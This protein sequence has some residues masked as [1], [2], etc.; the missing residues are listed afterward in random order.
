MGYDLHVCDPTGEPLATTYEDDL[1]F[2]R[3][4]FGMG[5]L[6]DALEAMGVGYWPVGGEVPFPTGGDD[7]AIAQWLRDTRDER[8][9]IPLHKLCSNDGWWVTA[10]ECRSALDLWERAGE[11]SHEEFRDDWIPF[12]QA[13]AKNGGFRTY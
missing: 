5:P 7:D 1:Y 11:P 4:I 6:R 13:A 8:P 2:R 12:L 3:N 9:G 10:V